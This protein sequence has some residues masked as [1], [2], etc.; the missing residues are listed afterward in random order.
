MA[1]GGAP[2]PPPL[3][4]TGD[5]TWLDFVL[6]NRWF[7][8]LTG[9]FVTPTADPGGNTIRIGGGQVSIA[10][11][12]AATGGSG[13]AMPRELC[14]LV[15]GWKPERY[16]L[17]RPL[18]YLVAYGPEP[19]FQCAA[20]AIRALFA[21]GLWE[22]DVLLLTDAA[23]LDFASRLPAVMRERVRVMAMPADDV[24]DYTLARYKIVDVK[25][26]E[27]YQP[28]PYLDTDIIRDA[29][30][31]TR[32]TAL[33]PELQVTPEFLLRSP[34][35]HYGQSLLAADGVVPDRDQP[36]FSSGLFAFRAVSE[37]RWLFR[38]I[39]EA[40]TRVTARAGNR[41]AYECYDQPF[42]NYVLHKT[43]SAGDTVF[44]DAVAL[45]LRSLPPL[46]APS[47][48][49]FVHFAGGVGVAAPKLAHMMGY[50]EML[51]GISSAPP[52]G[53]SPR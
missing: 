36:G 27:A 31:R 5:R 52:I 19:I 41:D 35:D 47:R 45:H 26:A 46:T 11:L 37:Q 34:D 9:A 8:C 24:L 1:E 16:V 39:I 53:T 28:V 43:R 32:L 49:G 50:Y 21:F 17:F 42:F 33:S 4:L 14:L 12:I 20:W 25:M 40:A 13:S 29:P 3:L 22:G 44:R 38:M 6:A 7:S 18:A 51:A 10:A 23:H 2:V 48:K 15:D 30:A